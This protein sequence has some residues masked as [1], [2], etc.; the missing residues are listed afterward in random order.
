M[1]MCVGVT[2]HDLSA[3]GESSDFVEKQGQ[4]HDHPSRVHVATCQEQ[5]LK[6]LDKLFEWASD[7]KNDHNL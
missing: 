5:W 4:K 1:K 2:S 3:N 7:A 6:G